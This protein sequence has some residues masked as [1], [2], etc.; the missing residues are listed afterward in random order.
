MTND[1]IDVRNR[2]VSP[3]RLHQVAALLNMP[4]LD[5]TTAHEDDAPPAQQQVALYTRIADWSRLSAQTAGLPGASDGHEITERFAYLIEY[6][7]QHA[8]GWHQPPSEYSYGIV[9]A[10]TAETVAQSVLPRYIT[11]LGEH[12]DEYHLWL[13]ATFTLRAS[14][15]HIND[16]ERERRGRRPG[17][18]SAAST[19]NQVGIPPHAIE[20]RTPSQIGRFLDH[21]DTS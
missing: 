10:E 9:Q 19:Y 17:W 15:W 20:V 3:S 18:A 12:R 1:F 16:A 13:T 4:Y 5:E 2:L 14:V 11:H 6:T 21:L 7:D 8:K